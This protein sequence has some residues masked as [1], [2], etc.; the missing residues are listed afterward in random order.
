MTYEEFRDEMTAY[1]RHVHREGIEWKDS[2][3]PLLQLKR[4]YRKLDQ[5]ERRMAD[6]VV[7]EWLLSEDPANRFY[8]RA[9]AREFRIASALPELQQ[10]SRQLSRH[11]GPVARDERETVDELMHTLRDSGGAERDQ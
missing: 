3:H 7:R 6:R 2:G 9:L 1:M 5:E 8:G 10:A 11:P 4:A